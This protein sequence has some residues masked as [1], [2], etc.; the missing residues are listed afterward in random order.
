MPRADSGDSGHV[1]SPRRTAQRATKPIPGGDDRVWE[2]IRGRHPPPG[3]DDRLQA[4]ARARATKYADEVSRAENPG[5]TLSIMGALKEIERERANAKKEGEGEEAK[6]EEVVPTHPLDLAAAALGDALGDAKRNFSAHP[7]A[8]WIDPAGLL[9]TREPSRGGDPVPPETSTDRADGGEDDLKPAMKVLSYLFTN[10]N[11]I[12]RM[13]IPAITR[14]V[15]HEMFANLPLTH[16]L[17]E[18]LIKALR[19]LIQNKYGTESTTEVLF[20][21]ILKTEDGLTL[22]DI[23]LTD[24]LTKL[25]EKQLKKIKTI[26]E[27]TEYLM[28]AIKGKIRTFAKAKLTARQLISL[29]SENRDSD[30]D[31]GKQ[32]PLTEDASVALRGLE[33]ISKELGFMTFEIELNRNNVSI[34]QN[35]HLESIK[36]FISEVLPTIRPYLERPDVGQGGGHRRTKNKSRKKSRKKSREKS[37]EKSKNK[38]MKKSKNKT[39]KKSKN[40]TMKKSKNKT[41][42]KSRRKTMKKKKRQYLKI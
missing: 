8:T 34:F 29:W 36:R 13:V 12:T 15:N 18:D 30:E 9:F 25:T 24:D 2:Y 23:D 42:K 21:A 37:R 16:L 32:T 1:D 19:T 17:S 40:K 31:S 6:K 27:L 4:Y 22:Q 35:N 38:T 28:E 41:M 3:K 39:M 10:K 20:D 14:L 33:T 26:E 5:T 11:R 7:A